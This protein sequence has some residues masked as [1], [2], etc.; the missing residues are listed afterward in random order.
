MGGPMHRRVLT[1]TAAASLLI[2]AAACGGDDDDDGASATTAAAGTTEAPGTTEAAATTD[3]A[4]TTE[5]PE[6]T[7]AEETDTTGAA[8]EPTGEPIKLMVIHEVELG[9]ANPEIPEGAEA[10]A[11]AINAEGG[12]GGRPI[13][14]LSCDTGNDPNQ[15]ADC[16][17]QA[18]DEGVV[19]V[20][21]SITPHSGSFIPLLE[22]NQIPAVGEIPS[23][24]A[25]YASPAVFPIYGGA[26][27]ALPRWATRSVRPVRR[28]SR[29]P[30]SIS[31]IA[32]ALNTQ[33]D[34]TALV[35]AVVQ[36]LT[37]T[38]R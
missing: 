20:I 10:A 21:S 36:A 6:T 5:A 32:F 13:E 18:V 27:W 24:G 12:V 1:V 17:R 35:I 31:T 16:G 19:A 2:A 22:E 37:A 11:Q 4:A 23:A 26:R 8:E 34:P 29:S 33:E 25:E 3:A 28:T 9:V 7:E 15:A 30:A 38:K 14:I